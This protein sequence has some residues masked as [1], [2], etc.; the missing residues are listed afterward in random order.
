M[1]PEMLLDLA[2][3]QAW[4]D[5]AHWKAIRENAALLED[6]EIRRRLNHM[7][8]AL[9][10]LTT[11]ARGQTPDAAGMKEVDSI[12]QLEAAMQ[13]AHAD[14]AAALGS[15]DLARMIALPR[16]P[17]GPF[18]APAGVLL[19]Q[20]L[21]HSQHHRGQNASRMRQLGAAPPMTDFVVWYAL[22]RP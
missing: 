21:T 16:G 2:R 19:L 13:K 17:N 5:M 9:K 6:V 7:V 8:T 20:A 15:A 18:A 4:A 14:L 12:D 1:N 22:G 10:M 11:L 3:H